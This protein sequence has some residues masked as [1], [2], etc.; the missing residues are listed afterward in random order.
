[1]LDNVSASKNFVTV[2]A[3]AEDTIN[4]KLNS[5]KRCHEPNMRQ[6]VAGERVYGR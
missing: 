4:W 1:M 5:I 2:L 3:E 6:Q